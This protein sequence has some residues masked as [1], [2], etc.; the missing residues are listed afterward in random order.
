MFIEVD[1][2]IQELTLINETVFHMFCGKKHFYYL[3]IKIPKSFF[4]NTT[5]HKLDDIH[6]ILR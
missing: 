3:N 4:L 2:M 1:N 6:M 5:N